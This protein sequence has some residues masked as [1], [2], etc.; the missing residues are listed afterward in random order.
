MA[1]RHRRRPSL[2]RADPVAAGS[3]TDHQRLVLVVVLGLA[4]NVDVP[5]GLGLAPRAGR[6][7]VEGY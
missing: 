3:L 6:L 1:G 7:C 4:R 5:R 2:D